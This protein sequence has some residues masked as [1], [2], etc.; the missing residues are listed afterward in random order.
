MKLFGSLDNGCSLSWEDS[1][2]TI[3]LLQKRL[4]KAILVGDIKTALQLQKIILHS[5]SS[6]LLAIRFVTQVC[7]NKKLAGVD[8]KTSLT[9]LERFE[10][11]EVLKLKLNNWTPQSLKNI[12]VLRNNGDSETLQIA[13]ISDR[14]WQ[15]LVKLSIEPAHEAVFHPRN[16]GFRTVYDI[17]HI[18]K[19]VSYNL[20][21][22]S[23]G[24]QKRVL[25]LDL[26]R[27]ISNY[28]KNYLLE[29]IISPRSIKV[30]LSRLLSKNIILEFFSQEHISCGLVSLF[31]NILLHG[32][33]DIHDS[34]RFGTSVIFF[35]KPKDD[36]KYLFS[37]ILSFLSSRGLFSKD[38][39][40]DVF[41]SLN[42]F[43]FLGWHFRVVNKANILITPADYDYQEF[44]VRVKRIVNNSN[45]GSN[46]KVNKLYPIVKKWKHYH[47]F[48][49]LKGARFSLYFI[50]K[51]AFKVFSKESRQDFFSTKRLVNKC[52]Y[53]L[54]SFEKFVLEGNSLASPYRGHLF[55]VARF[56]FSPNISCGCIHCGM[57]VVP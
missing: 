53:T 48:S 6:R 31:F 51:R 10:L 13:T 46:V 5:N 1:I 41:S 2:N 55:F 23:F 4:F 16:F 22:L 27:R 50:K 35:L 44:L 18:Q 30:S 7:I 34:V 40:F 37:V 36:E 45:Y 26:S 8:G 32:I 24:S 20:D 56:T 12:T 38:I 28:N 9:F 15:T 3:F 29:N 49:C 19:N 54:N 43:D 33:E 47:R 17:H 52:F 14:V 42:G 57:I 39:Y 11:N 25:K 21:Q